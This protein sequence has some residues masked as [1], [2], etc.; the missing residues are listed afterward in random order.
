MY[1]GWKRYH[2]HQTTNSPTEARTNVHPANKHEDHSHAPQ[3]D[4]GN[5]I[6]Y[7]TGHHV[8][9]ENSIHDRW[10]DSNTDTVTHIN[11]LA[12]PTRHVF[13]VHTE[14]GGT[15]YPSDGTS[16]HTSP[17]RIPQTYR[18]PYAT[19]NIGDSPRRQHPV[20]LDSGASQSVLRIASGE[21]LLDFHHP[22]ERPSRPAIATVGEL[23][24][25]VR[26][27]TSRDSPAID[28]GEIGPDNGS[29]IARSPKRARTEGALHLQGGAWKRGATP[30]HTMMGMSPQAEDT[31]PTYGQ[32]MYFM[33]PMG[34]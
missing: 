18:A 32:L 20:V 5:D 6:A 3:Y 17:P 9:R 2:Y 13:M 7:Q 25:R 28:D 15:Q 26:E 1:P 11:T 34:A 14:G 22:R 23:S 21:P 33:G 4:T 31:Q 29:S 30:L 27:D 12:F 8:R 24:A 10:L 16:E 19:G